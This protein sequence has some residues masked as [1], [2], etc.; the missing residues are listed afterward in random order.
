MKSVGTTQSTWAKISRWF[1]SLGGMRRG[2]LLGFTI[3]L[4]LSVIFGLVGAALGHDMEDSAGSRVI[5]TALMTFD[6]PG[7]LIFAEVCNARGGGM[8]PGGNE[9][10][11]MG[12]LVVC[13]LPACVF[14]A[15]IGCT[16]GWMIRMAKV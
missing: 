7:L 10:M 14:W 13:T 15:F 5:G 1:L 11:A 2:L 16:I 3:P 9:S 6:F 4:L 12:F 8:L